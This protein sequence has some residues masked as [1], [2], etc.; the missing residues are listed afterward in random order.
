MRDKLLEKDFQFGMH[1]GGMING[2][3]FTN[4]LEALKYWL[5]HG[6]KIFE[7]DIDVTQDGDYVA[8]HNFNKDVLGKME[9]ENIPEI[10]TKEWFL[11][12]KL[13][14]ESTSGLTTMDLQ[15]VI[16]LLHLYRDICIMIDPKMY[17]YSA[18]YSLLKKLQLLINK[19]KVD[20]S[21]IIVET[22]NFDMI[23]ATKEF[24][25]IF[26]FQYCVDDEIQM[27]NS[28]QMRK[29]PIEKQI[30]I[31]KKYDIKIVSYPWKFAVEKL[32]IIKKLKEE[33]FI[34]FSKTRN[35]IFCDLLKLAGVNVN[36]IDH[37][38]TEEQK[39]LLLDYKEKYYE[40]Y[41]EKIKEI[42]KE[43]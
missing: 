36:L 19:Y 26:Q 33:G 4:S 27:G 38:V 31:L 6:I 40:Q 14:A 5:S 2:I 37:L 43:K 3:M 1:A 11:N 21:R 9:I 35:D 22:Y 8:C 24:R 15:K 18:Y 12:Q 7:L 32:E 23:Q 20:G 17:S 42:F 41:E 13:Y 25:D 16:E 39:S 28:E 34:L 10:C 29:L 30:E